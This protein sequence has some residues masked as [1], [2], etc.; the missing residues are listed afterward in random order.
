M[1]LLLTVLTPST[2]RYY[3]RPSSPRTSP[4]SRTHPRL[5]PDSARDPSPAPAIRAGDDPL[6]RTAVRPLGAAIAAAACAL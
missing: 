1:V 6:R 4:R 2:Q 3:D 5:D